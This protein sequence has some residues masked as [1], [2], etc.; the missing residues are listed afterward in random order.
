VLARASDL[1]DRPNSSWLQVC[2]QLRTCLQVNT[3]K[4]KEIVFG[5]FARHNTDLL[6]SSSGE[7][8]RVSHFKLLG[9]YTDATLAWKIHN[10]YITN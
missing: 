2:D 5:S 4:I 3:R 1:D 8:E 9:V 10:D 7:I 6:T